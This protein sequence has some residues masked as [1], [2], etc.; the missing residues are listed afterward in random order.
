MTA[1]KKTPK[2][3]TDTKI[4][5]DMQ[6]WLLYAVAFL[7]GGI[8]LWVAFTP[9]ST[10]QAVVIIDGQERQLN[11]DRVE[12]SSDREFA[13]PRSARV[14]HPEDWFQAG[15]LNDL[16]V[17]LEYDP[18]DIHSVQRK[19]YYAAVTGGCR[20]LSELERLRERREL[21]E[22]PSFS[23]RPAVCGD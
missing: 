22:N 21:C 15:R 18:C 11:V 16:C 4:P 13:C 5:Q 20:S 8:L 3:A 12:L 2:R 10:A 6:A 23:P 1:R 7:I 19:I 17:G 14:F 9:D